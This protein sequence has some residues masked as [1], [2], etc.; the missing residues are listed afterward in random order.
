MSEANYTLW[1]RRLVNFIIDL[2]IIFLLLIFIIFLFETFINVD[3]FEGF[4]RFWKFMDQL[5]IIFIGVYLLYYILLESIFGLTIGKIITGTRLVDYQGNKPAFGK[6][7]LRSLIRLIPIEWF[8]YL[9]KYPLGWHDSLS[10]TKVVGK[11]LKTI[12]DLS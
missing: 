2:A 12:N 10:K 4:F 6:V 1:W 3:G 7:L 5:E 9:T 8:T 11:D